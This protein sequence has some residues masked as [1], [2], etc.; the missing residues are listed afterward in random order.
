MT[1]VSLHDAVFVDGFCWWCSCWCSNLGFRKLHDFNAAQLGELV[2]GLTWYGWFCSHFVHKKG[3]FLC[4]FGCLVISRGK[5]H[6]DSY[7]IYFFLLVMR[8]QPPTPWCWGLCLCSSK[9]SSSTAP[10]RA[11][12]KNYWGGPMTCSL[13]SSGIKIWLTSTKDV[14]IPASHV[15]RVCSSTLIFFAAG[16]KLTTWSTYLEPL[17]GQMGRR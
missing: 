13:G 12:E 3:I 17:S 7:S 16:W 10:G 9:A 5:C 14:E 4:F 11:E 6:T 8:D 15:V 1:I 2:S